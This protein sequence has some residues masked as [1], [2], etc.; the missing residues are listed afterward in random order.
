MPSSKSLSRLFI[1]AM[2]V[3]VA[4]GFL[5]PNRPASKQSTFDEVMLILR[6]VATSENPRGQLDD[7]S[8]LEYARRFGFRGEVLDVAGNIS[9]DSAQVQ[10]G[11]E[12]IRNDKTITA[13][14]GFRRRLQCSFDLG[15]T[16]PSRA[17][18]HPQSSGDWSARG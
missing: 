1:P 15:G 8:A 4:I 5:L 3:A 2:L 9:G 10:L 12:R 17:R 14:Y 11:L 18:P 6:G 16:E 7:E 13:I